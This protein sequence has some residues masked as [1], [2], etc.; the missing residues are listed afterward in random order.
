MSSRCLNFSSKASKFLDSLEI[1]QRKQIATKI[2]KLIED[3]R[4]QSSRRLSSQ[5]GLFRL[6]V[7][8]YRAIY[9][10]VPTEITV[11]AIGHRSW[12]YE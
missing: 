6:R 2:A 12:I 3:P 5:P 8:D 1:A 10:F 7:G 11:I 4:P 9:K